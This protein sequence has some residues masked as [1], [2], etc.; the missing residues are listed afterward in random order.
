MEKVIEEL[1]IENARLKQVEQDHVELQKSVQALHDMKDSLHEKLLN[2]KDKEK[3]ESLQSKLKEMEHQH[4]QQEERHKENLAKL[5]DRLDKHYTAELD[6][7]KEQCRPRDIELKYL[8]KEREETKVL[9]DNEQNLMLSSFHELGL[10]YHVLL[11][12]VKGG[13]GSDESIP[14]ELRGYGNPPGRRTVRDSIMQ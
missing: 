13:K 6:A 4:R 3:S 2:E 7:V 8:R 11:N 9:H 12:K 14:Q 10:R 5:R 1:T